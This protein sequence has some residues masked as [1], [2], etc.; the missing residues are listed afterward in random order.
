MTLSGLSQGEASSEMHAKCRKIQ[1]VDKVHDNC[2]LCKLKKL[3][4]KKVNSMF[5]VGARVILK[6]AHRNVCYANKVDS[7]FLV[8]YI[9]KSDAVTRVFFIF[10]FF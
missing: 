4:P 8:E 5:L 10:Y 3:R 1:L 7:M 6:R 9:F 2:E